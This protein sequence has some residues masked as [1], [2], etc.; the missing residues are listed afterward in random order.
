[1]LKMQEGS[2][3]GKG[4]NLVVK[5]AEDPWS[6]PWHLQVKKS[7]AGGLE[8]ISAS[9]PPVKVDSP[10]LA[11]SVDSP[12]SHSLYSHPTSI[13]LICEEKQEDGHLC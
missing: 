3:E 7:P 13:W 1:M 5:H 11:G 9:V 2:E 6:S 8:T 4:N 12:Y 10:W